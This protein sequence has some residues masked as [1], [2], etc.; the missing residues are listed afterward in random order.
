MNS[1]Q[2]LRSVCCSFR[3]GPFVNASNYAINLKLQSMASAP[4]TVMG[5]TINRYM[6]NHYS[7][8]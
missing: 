3:H 5:L 1:E 6:Y 4:V 7:A 2:L 8:Y